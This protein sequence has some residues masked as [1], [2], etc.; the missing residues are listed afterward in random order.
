MPDLSGLL[1]RTVARLARAG[2]EVITV[3]QSEPGLRER[4]G[5]H[6]VKVVVPGALPMTFGHVNRRTLG[7]SR[8]LDVP[9]RLGRTARPVHHG[10]LPLHPHPFP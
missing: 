7:L 3:D 2:L 10:E 4:F 5:L 9:H 1:T 6:C 8:L